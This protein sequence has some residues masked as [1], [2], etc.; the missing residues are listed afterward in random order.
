MTEHMLDD[1]RSLVAL[2]Y[3]IQSGAFF[4]DPDHDTS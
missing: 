4:F 3:I 1:Y 2:N